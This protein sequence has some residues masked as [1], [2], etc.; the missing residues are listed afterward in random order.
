[1]VSRIL[2]HIQ[3]N[4]LISPQDVVL[5]G[6][7]GGADSVCLLCVLLELRE[8]LDIRINVIHVNHGIR[9][10][11]L[12]DETFVKEL[13]EKK[14]IPYLAVLTDVTGYAKKNGLSVE[15]AGRILRYEAFEAA[16]QGVPEEKRKI[17]VAHNMDDNAETMLFNMFRGTGI[18]GICG[19]PVK[20]GCIIRPL[21]CVGRKQIEEYL[22]QK[23]QSY[24]IDETNLTDTYMR[25]KIRH[26]ILPKAEEINEKAIEKM[27]ELSADLSM[28]ERFL[29]QQVS[30]D[31]YEVTETENDEV[32]I[33]EDIFKNKH[34]YIQERI[35]MRALEL[36]AGSSKDF[37]R[38]HVRDVITLMGMQTGKKRTLPYEISA[39]RTYRG[40]LL[41]RDVTFQEEMLSEE[42]KQVLQIPGRYSCGENKEL[43]FRVTD[44]NLS[45]EIPKD[46]YTKWL[47]YD[48]IKGNLCVRKR[49]EGDYLIINSQGQHQ[50]LKSY[51]INEKIPS[52]ERDNIFLLAEG[53]HILWVIGYRISEAC[54]V[55]KSTKKILEIRIEERENTKEGT[56]VYGCKNKS[57]DIGRGH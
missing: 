1:M 25:N 49:Q 11:A 30:A 47:D 31:F 13:C 9:A 57:N 42:G 27:Y 19:I 14:E 46:R 39:Y 37:T 4:E 2:R 48:T 8:I 16:L 51:F 12:R 33:N 26:H 10:T 29:N 55:T 34:P 28:A 41:K 7:S 32:M 22:S 45:T 6:V 52:W 40:I 53:S 50:R 5:A 21:L 17:A 3:E 38:I 54:K 18:K 15:E 36:L 35:V 20:R 23:G 44:N 56:D 24:C 43:V